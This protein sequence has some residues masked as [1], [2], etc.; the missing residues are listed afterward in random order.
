MHQ[1]RKCSLNSHIKNRDF[2]FEL[3]VP[4]F[5]KHDKKSVKLFCVFTAKIHFKDMKHENG[6]DLDSFLLKRKTKKERSFMWKKWV[7]G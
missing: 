5:F 2:Y 7:T 6:L 4:L 1:D 3:F